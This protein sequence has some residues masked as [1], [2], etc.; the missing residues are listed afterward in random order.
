M[1]GYN[2]QD[3]TIRTKSTN[4]DNTE[5]IGKKIDKIGQ[6]RVKIGQE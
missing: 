5:K 3:K 1:K 6:K 2:E 4:L